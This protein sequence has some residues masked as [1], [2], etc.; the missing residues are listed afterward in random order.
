M[1][2]VKIYYCDKKYSDFKHIPD[3]SII[4]LTLSH[5]LSEY[6][7]KTRDEIMKKGI[8]INNLSI[9]E[10]YLNNGKSNDSNFGYMDHTTE[11]MY[12]LKELFDKLLIKKLSLNNC[13][14]EDK[15]FKFICGLLQNNETIYELNIHKIYDTDFNSLIEL[16]K[17]NK[18]ITNISITNC[19]LELNDTV[20]YL[21]L[22][23]NI[24]YLDLRGNIINIRDTQIIDETFISSSMDK[25]KLKDDTFIYKNIQLKGNMVGY[26][27]GQ[28]I[29][30]YLKKE[31]NDIYTY[32]F[33]TF[34]VENNKFNTLS[35][36]NNMI[37]SILNIK[38]GTILVKKISI[39]DKHLKILNYIGNKLRF[40]GIMLDSLNLIRCSVEWKTLHSIN[41]LKYDILRCINLSN[42]LLWNKGLL[43]LT[44]VIKN[45]NNLKK[46][47]LNNTRITDYS[48]LIIEN[49]N[50]SNLEIKYNNLLLNDIL[51]LFQLPK[52]KTLNVE[53]NNIKIDNVE[54]I[55]QLTENSM[56]ENMIL[57]YNFTKCSKIKLINNH[58]KYKP[59]NDGYDKAKNSFEK[60][61]I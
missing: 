46:L 50:I 59:N 54:Y 24:K 14:I 13:K 53:Y 47:V 60:N 58:L 44:D 27:K 30:L 49:I 21:L 19:A 33:D 29:K 48:P 31:V 61:F 52:L 45:C 16:L 32:H 57:D 8:L 56:L 12:I 1:E 9:C 2:Y 26:Y 5:H 22:N 41:I 40:S 17:V 20:K 39:E 37:T 55:N 35:K 25:L 51:L 18:I 34:F 6:R 36:T 23:D 11:Y 3:N 38:Q 43:Y 42:N 10:L 7:Y 4:D 28:E 15:Y